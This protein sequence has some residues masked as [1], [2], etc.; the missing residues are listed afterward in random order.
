MPNTA[1]RSIFERVGIAPVINAC[2]IYTDLGGSILST[3]V[4]DALTDLNNSFIDIVELLNRTGERI[5]ELVGAEAAR[6]TPSA[7]AAIAL[8]VAACMVSRD[9]ALGERLPDVTGL[10]GELVFQRQQASGYKY[11]S[12]VRLPGARIVLVGDD[13][14]VSRKDVERAIGERSAAIFVPAHLDS[15]QGCLR[16]EELVEIAEPR[17]LPV[18]VDAAYMSD[19][20]SLLRT[21]AL[22]GA[23]LTCFSAKYFHGPNAGGFVSGRRKYVEAV[24][25]LEFTQHESGPYRRFGRAFKQ[26]RCEIAAVALALEEWVAMDHAKRL[27]ANAARA[28]ELRNLLG[29]SP[30]FTVSLGCFTLDARLVDSPVNAA[31]LTLLPEAPLAPAQLLARMAIGNPSIRA[32]DLD[33]RIILVT[34]TLRDGEQMIVGR[35]ILEALRSAQRATE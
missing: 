19:P 27:S 29:Q 17:G 6:V 12:P 4:W 21:F 14:R 24:R 25:D 15:L 30:W 18:I 3:T 35:R 28:E 31:I 9:A 23:S 33:G 1:R 8:S 5:A 13:A 22:R 26:G 11:M 10:K 34:E 7:S 32:I 16:I 20:P 2:G